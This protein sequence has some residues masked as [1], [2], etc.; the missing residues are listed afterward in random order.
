MLQE[1]ERSADPIRV[2]EGYIAPLFSLPL[3]LPATAWH[4]HI[5]FLFVLFRNL[6]PA[7]YVDLGVHW[8]ASLIA[9]A[10]ASQAYDLETELW[11]IDTWAGDIHT[12][13]YEGDEMYA[14]LR[15]YLDRNFSGVHLLRSTF[16]HAREGFDGRP[17]DLLHIDGLHTYEAVK[18]D[19]DTWLPVMS[20][21]GVVLFHDTMERDHGFGVWRLW[22]ELKHEFPSLEFV[23]SHGLGVLFVGAKSLD[24]PFLKRL[25]E[26][27]ARF[28][29]YRA[30]VS[31]IAGLLPFRCAHLHF[32]AELQSFVANG[33]DPE[34]IVQRYKAH[35]EPAAKPLLSRT[36]E[37]RGLAARVR[38][39]LK[40]RSR[41]ATRRPDDQ[42]EPPGK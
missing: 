35:M 20:E 32:E 27:P 25:V 11:G 3:K 16:D 7:R 38:R 40:G 17:V 2:H 26:D 30:T 4:G 21:R 6:K 39:W 34:E 36:G 18:H 14:D 10:S 8:G 9:A 12:Q 37:S 23:H 41:G 33:D 28:E 31:R 13:A 22:E 42:G 1:P 15:S 29:S 19:F 24:D 5:P